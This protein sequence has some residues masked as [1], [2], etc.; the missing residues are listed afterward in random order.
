MDVAGAR[1]NAVDVVVVVPG[2]VSRRGVVDAIPDDVVLKEVARYVSVLDTVAGPDAVVD[3][4]V[5]ESVV[6]TCA[7]GR[8]AIVID[9]VDEVVLDQTVAARDLA[10][11]SSNHSISLQTSR[12][13]S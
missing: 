1:K 8:D 5:P 13:R 7:T 12:S 11:L 6:C 3:G 4:V 10:C 2:R 9:V